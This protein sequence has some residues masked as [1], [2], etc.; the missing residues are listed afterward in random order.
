V[1]QRDLL[2]KIQELETI[3]HS[4]R[5]P[6][7]ALDNSWISSQWEERL[8]QRPQTQ[9]DPIETITTAEVSPQAQFAA[10]L[11]Q[12]TSSLSDEQ[13]V[14]ARL[15]SE[16]PD[17]VRVLFLFS[18]SVYANSCKLKNPPVSQLKQP[19]EEA[20]NWSTHEDDQLQEPSL[21]IP[22]PISTPVGQ[23]ELHPNP[24]HVFKLWQMFVDN[25]NPLIKIIHAPT[26]QEKILEAAWSPESTAK[27]L[28]AIML[29]VYALAVAS[30]K[31]ASCVDLLGED[32][33]VLVNRYRIGALRALSGSDL[34]STRDME[35]L[36]ALTLSL[37]SLVYVILL[38]K[39]MNSNLFISVASDD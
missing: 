36:Q 29:A 15:W 30:M 23:L 13:A 21:F 12:I 20:G 22:T 34:L 37:V 27:P 32:K 4:N 38:E 8:V 17:I 11:N 2:S 10:N 6:F 33:Q 16:L 14:A 3:L 28:E 31:P 24:K 25:V 19:D 1:T 35:V 39:K 18:D 26:L 9:A 7:E 5:I